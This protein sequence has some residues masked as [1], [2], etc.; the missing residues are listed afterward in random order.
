MDLPYSAAC[1]RNQAH[2]LQV[3][4]PYLNN[5]RT[6]LEVGSGTAQ[7]AIFFAQ[8]NPQLV[9]Q[10]AD[11]QHY[12]AGIHAQLAA[13]NL[14]NVLLPIELD[15]NRSDWNTVKQKF[16]LIYT[17][18]T[19][20]IMSAQEVQAF[21]KGL[22]VISDSQ[23][24]LVIYGP[25]KYRGQFTSESNQDFDQSLR[26]RDV[27]SCIKDFEEIERLAN[28][29]GFEIVLDQT[30]PANNQCLIWQRSASIE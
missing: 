10:T 13:A 14:E 5:A 19:L 12:L 15:V 7:H 23:S 20:H 16:D 3:M 30:M 27:G 22:P 17:A 28:Q 21:F 18:N 11:Q 1:E 9:W 26:S 4:S 6:V 2:I 29:Q 24:L 8:A 25:F